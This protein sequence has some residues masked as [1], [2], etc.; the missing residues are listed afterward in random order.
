MSSVDLL[1]DAL[2]ED[3]RLHAPGTKIYAWLKAT[4]RREIEQ[5]FSGDQPVAAE[6][7]RFGQICLPY[8]RMG[9]IDSLDLFAREVMPKLESEP[10]L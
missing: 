2:L 4:A 7:G 8:Y 3:V 9:A 10:V 6:F 5:R 1:F